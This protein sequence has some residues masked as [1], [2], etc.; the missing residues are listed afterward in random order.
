MGVLHRKPLGRVAA[1]PVFAVLAL[2]A[3]LAVPPALAGAGVQLAGVSYRQGYLD[4]DGQFVGGGHYYGQLTPLQQEVYQKVLKEVCRF[5]D[6]FSVGQAGWKD[7][8]AA[9]LAVYYDHEEIWWIGKRCSFRPE[10]GVHPGYLCFFWE[11]RPKQAAIE[12]VVS[13]ALSGCPDGDDYDKLQYVYRWLVDHVEYKAGDYSSSIY[14]VFAQGESVC[15]GYARGM[16]YLLSELGVE[17]I[18]TLGYIGGEDPGYH[19][20]CLVKLGDGW[21]HS[22]PTWGEPGNGDGDVDWKYLACTDNFIN[23]MHNGG[24]IETVFLPDS[25]EVPTCYPSADRVYL[26]KEQEALLLD[27]WKDDLGL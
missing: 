18:Y 4:G 6:G 27:M 19:A 12:A 21:Y 13:R 10:T 25:S 5:G 2:F 22:D 16:M 3:F 11:Y 8:W 7:L 23:I 24:S 17:S 9:Y 15:S 26:S 14:S 1:G 20:W